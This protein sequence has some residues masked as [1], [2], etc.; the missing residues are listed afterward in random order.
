MDGAVRYWIKG[1]T[2]VYVCMCIE[3]H[4]EFERPAEMDHLSAFQKIDMPVTSLLSTI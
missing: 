2:L 3:L 4:L 1:L